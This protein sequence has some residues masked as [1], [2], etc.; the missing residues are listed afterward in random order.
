MRGNIITPGP[1]VQSL[2]GAIRAAVKTG[3]T[4]CTLRLNDGTTH[5]FVIAEQLDDALLGARVNRPSAACLVQ[6]ASIAWIEFG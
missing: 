1:P 3:S 6:F 2:R 5:D 4:R